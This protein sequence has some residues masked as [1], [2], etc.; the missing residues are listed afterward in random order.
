MRKIITIGLLICLATYLSAQVNTKKVDLKFGIGTSLQGSGDMTTLSFENELNYKINKYFS[1]SFAIDYGK[2]DR[3][4][5]ASTSLVQGNLN[6]YFSPFKNSGK[7]NFKIG[8]GLSAMKVSDFYALSITQENYGVTTG[9]FVF[10]K[11]NSLGFNIIIENEYILSKK[12]LIG[13]KL[14]T[15]PYFN[16]DIS[17]GGFLKFGVIL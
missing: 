8:T 1:I 17:T 6:I 7:N 15:Q 12:Y 10:E 5:N 2:S 9:D 3:G 14:F 16:G 11:R 4:V 13:L